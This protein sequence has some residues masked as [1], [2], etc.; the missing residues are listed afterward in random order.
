MTQTEPPSAGGRAE[1]SQPLAVDRGEEALRGGWG[2]WPI[3]AQPREWVCDLGWGTPLLRA[4]ECPG[5]HS[6]VGREQPPL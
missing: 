1:T 3:Q 4:L 6:A 2:T 5:A